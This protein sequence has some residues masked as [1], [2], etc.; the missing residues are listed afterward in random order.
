VTALL[1][2]M[3]SGVISPESQLYQ[4]LC[5]AITTFK[6]KQKTFRHLM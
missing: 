2:I 5:Y 3:N 6:P 4:N 1:Y